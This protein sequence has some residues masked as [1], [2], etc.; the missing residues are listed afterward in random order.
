MEGTD[1]KAGDQRNSFAKLPTL[2]EYLWLKYDFGRRTTHPRY[3]PTAVR[4]HDFQI[5]IVHFMS[6]RP[7]LVTTQPSLISARMFKFADVVQLN[8]HILCSLWLKLQMNF[9]LCIHEQ[10]S[11]VLFS[12]WY[13]L[14]QPILH[15][16]LQLN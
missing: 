11:R 14:I 2:S 9:E 1:T 5:M 4:A 15:R 10:V 12:L 16:N 6:L 8:L 7:L 3:D 13:I